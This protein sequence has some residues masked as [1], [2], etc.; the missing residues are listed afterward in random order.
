MYEFVRKYTIIS[1]QS[2][3]VKIVIRR[4]I[5]VTSETRFEQNIRSG[6]TWEPIINLHFEIVQFEDSLKITINLLEWNF[7]LQMNTLNVVLMKSYKIYLVSDVN[8]FERKMRMTKLS[9]KDTE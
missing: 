2:F 5:E 6:F 9:E 3:K 7:V 8:F 1:I 4:T